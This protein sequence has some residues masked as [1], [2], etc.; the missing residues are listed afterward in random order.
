MENLPLNNN[1][2]NQQ[3]LQ[4]ATRDDNDDSEFPT[5]QHVSDVIQEES[6][7][8]PIKR[9]YTGVRDLKAISQ[10]QIIGEPSHGIRIKSSLIT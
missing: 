10:N 3:F 2:H 8:L 4:I 5:H 9:R 1:A 7:E 6:E